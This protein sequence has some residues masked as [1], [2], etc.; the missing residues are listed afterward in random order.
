MTKYNFII[1]L[2]SLALICAE[3]NKKL[4]SVKKALLSQNWKEAF[5]WFGE[6]GER[7]RH[8]IYTKKASGYETAFEASI[9]AKSSIFYFTKTENINY[10]RSQFRRIDNFS[11]R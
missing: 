7:F 8:L 11:N 3:N 4:Y 10:A 1:D 6:E 9:A 2:Y 5:E